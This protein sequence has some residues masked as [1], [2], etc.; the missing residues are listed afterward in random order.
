MPID[1]VE[2]YK[3][4]EQESLKRPVVTDGKKK[5]TVLQIIEQIAKATG[6]KELLLAAVYKVVRA[7]LKKKG[8]DIQRSYFVQIVNKNFKTKKKDNRVY[9][10][11][12]K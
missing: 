3:A 12:G 8:M 6:Q 7:E 1:L 9:I 10:V 11:V 4:A 5:E 2:L